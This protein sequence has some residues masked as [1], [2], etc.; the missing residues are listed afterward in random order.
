MGSRRCVARVVVPQPWLDLQPSGGAAA[1]TSLVTVA[2]LLWGQLTSVATWAS[3]V[4]GAAAKAWCLC[5]AWRGERCPCQGGKE[6]VQKCSITPDKELP[7]PGEFPPSWALCP[8]HP[9]SPELSSWVQAPCVGV[10]LS[11]QNWG[12]VSK[13]L[14]CEGRGSEWR[15]DLSVSCQVSWHFH[16]ELGSVGA[17]W[18]G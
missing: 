7:P 2:G 5:G 6:V 11:R 15:A 12:V 17:L 8:I 9:P 13:G 3:V 4:P 18:L 16:D 10:V 1:P 14:L